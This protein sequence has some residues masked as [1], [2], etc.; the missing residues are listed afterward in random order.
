MTSIR[1]IQQDDFE[2]W[3]VLWSGY[4]RFYESEIADDVTRATFDRLVKDRELHGALAIDEEGHAI[5]LVHWLT[6]AA[7]WSTGEYCYLEDLFVAPDARGSG[8][9][10]AM[11]AHVREW[12]EQAGCAKLYWLTQEGNATARTLYDRVATNTGFTHYQIS[13]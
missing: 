1:A 4:L 7:T 8:S 11:I 6:H 12:A 10:R 2:E 9:G 3:S 13:L 5:G